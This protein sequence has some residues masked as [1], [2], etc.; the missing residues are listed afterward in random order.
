MASLMHLKIVSCLDFW[1][2]WGLIHPKKFAAK[3][4]LTVT[5]VV[6]TIITFCKNSFKTYCHKPIDAQSIS[7]LARA[8]FAPGV[9]ASLQLRT[10]QK[11]KLEAPT[12]PALRFTGLLLLLH[13][14]ISHYQATCQIL[15]LN[16]YRSQTNV[17]MNAISAR[18]HLHP[19]WCWQHFT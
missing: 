2:F 16:L 12:P 13:P 10:T 1:I 4:K 14:P 17:A 5:W 19:I 8:A 9:I 3:L 6:L 18:S 15:P 11:L 7:N